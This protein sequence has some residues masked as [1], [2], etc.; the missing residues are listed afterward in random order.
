[1][2]T[3]YALLVGIDRYRPPLQRLFGACNDIRDVE[4]Y[5]GEVSAED[6]RVR[7]LRDGEATLDGVVTA[8]IDHLGQAG[9]GDSAL[10]WFSGHGST[11]PVPPSLWHAEPSGELQVLVCVDSR[12]GGVPDLVDKDLAVL[13]DGVADRGAH[14]VVVLDCCHSSATS[15]G[16]GSALPG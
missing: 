3:V 14:V 5:L 13:V 7:T 8:F 11:C 6:V 15:S 12:H 9:A 16:A 10:F 1:M 2:G 4:S